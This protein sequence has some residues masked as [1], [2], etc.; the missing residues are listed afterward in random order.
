[1]LWNNLGIKRGYSRVISSFKGSLCLQHQRMWWIDDVTVA[2]ISDS[3]IPKSIATA[4]LW[5]TELGFGNFIQ[6]RHW[7]SFHSDVFFSVKSFL[8][9]EWSRRKNIRLWNMCTVSSPPC[10]ENIPHIIKYRTLH[11]KNLGFS[12]EQRLY[13]MPEERPVQ[14]RHNLVVNYPDNV[15]RQ[16]YTLSNLNTPATCLN[17]HLELLSALITSS[18]QCCHKI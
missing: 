17:L 6:Y 5:A 14:H 3:G 13:I 16:Q 7:L 4:W 1:M 10:S 8:V 12:Q 18:K 2:P 11:S 9:F 15:P